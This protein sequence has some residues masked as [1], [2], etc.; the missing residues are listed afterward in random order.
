[1]DDPAL[2]LQAKWSTMARGSWGLGAVVPP[3]EKPS[4][5]PDKLGA[6]DLTRPP[7]R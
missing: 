7:D 4:S 5:F 3:I 2:S 6:R 1:M